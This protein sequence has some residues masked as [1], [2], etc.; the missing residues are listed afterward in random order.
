VLAAEWTLRSNPGCGQC[1]H[2]S[3]N[4]FPATLATDDE[5]TLTG[6]PLEHAKSIPQVS[7][8]VLLGEKTMQAEELPASLALS[9]Q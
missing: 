6:W 3:G 8:F 7:L 2:R 5:R 1:L 4:V 9:R